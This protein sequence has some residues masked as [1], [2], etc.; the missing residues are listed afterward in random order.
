MASPSSPEEGTSA[1]LLRAL[2]FAAER[3]RHQRRKGVDR[4]PFINH[5]IE[6]AEIL[7][8]VAGVEDPVTL[9][10]AVLHDTLEDT[11]T[12]PGELEAEFGA[13]V[14]SVVEEVTDEKRLPREECRRLQVER[15][16]RLSAPAKLVRLADK[17]ANARAVARTPPADWTL[18]RRREYLDWA[19]RVAAGC[20][21][22]SPELDRLWDATIEEGRLLLDGEE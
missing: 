16:P 21:G 9:Q 17:I 12:A 8:R 19:E 11:D 4:S 6:V 5:P 15:A 13:A 1:A 10:A 22:E 3:H 14:R 7:A 2:R 20:R 18:V